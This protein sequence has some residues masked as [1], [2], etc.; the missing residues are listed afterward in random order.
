MHFVNNVD[1]EIVDC[2]DDKVKLKNAD[3]LSHLDE[4]LCHLSSH[5][6][7]E[8]G[9]MINTFEHL[10]PDVP[11]K[12]TLMCHDVD[13]GDAT[14]I[15]QHPY[16]LNPEKAEHLKKEITYMLE[17]D[18]IEPSCNEWSS[19][20][21]VLVPKPYKSYRFCTDVRKV[22][23]VTKPDSYHIPRI[24]DCID[25]IGHAKYVTKFDLLKGY[26]QVPLTERAN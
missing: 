7:M 15:K 19:P 5:E 18:I 17:N 6:R 11:H 24:D 3:V 14:P 10:F 4:K 9:N 25:K 1:L 8:M 23:V 16:R 12:T 22:N 21:C 13:V 2:V 26:W 20:P